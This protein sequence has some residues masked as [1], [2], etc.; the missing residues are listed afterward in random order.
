MF[1]PSHST[2]RF[3]NVVKT[4]LQSTFLWTVFLYLIP[5][6]LVKFDNWGF[7]QM[8]LLGWTLFCTFSFLGVFSGLSISI[9]GVGTPLPLDC[10]NKLVIRGPYKYV[11]NPM[12]I[13]GIGQGISA[14]LILG[15]SWVLV[16][17]IL[18]AFLWNL[19]VRPL[20]ERDLE[21]RFGSHFRQYKNNI[22]CWIPKF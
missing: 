9:Y 7:E 21:N 13:A 1:Y 12:A 4:L 10:A 17:A 19:I 11:R 14:G 5:K 16:Y 22:N 8:P 18:G 15:S 20:E 6:F 3:F 2:N